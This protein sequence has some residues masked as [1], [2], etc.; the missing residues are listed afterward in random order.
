ME[1]D[2]G[3]VVCIHVLAFLLDQNLFYA[4]ILRA[5]SYRY[6]ID[7]KIVVVGC[8]LYFRYRCTLFM[9]QYL[10]IVY[11]ITSE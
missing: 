9:L 3:A 6:I 1:P 10:D 4:S 7:N 2:L 5:M 11:L 8:L